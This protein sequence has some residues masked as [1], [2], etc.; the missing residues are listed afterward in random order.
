MKL[1]GVLLGL[2]LG[3]AASAALLMLALGLIHGGIESV[4]ALGFWSC[5]GIVLLLQIVR[6]V[7]SR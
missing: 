4:P 5:F 3:A 1:V 2:A 7:S 6:G